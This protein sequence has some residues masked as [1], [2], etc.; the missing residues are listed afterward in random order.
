[1]IQFEING[2]EI[3]LKIKNK[4]NISSLSLYREKNVILKD[5]FNTIIIE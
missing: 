4:N 2:S 5:Q 1:M 3:K